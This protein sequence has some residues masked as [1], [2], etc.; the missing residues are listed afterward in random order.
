MTNASWDEEAI[1]KALLRRVEASRL[2]EYLKEPLEEMIHYEGE[3]TFLSASD[4]LLVLLVFTYIDLLGYLY[5]GKNSS[6]NAV[7]FMREYLGRVDKRYEE[8]SGLLYDALR[9]GYIHLATP[10]R[11]ELQD[12]KILDFSFIR[13]GWRE[14]YLKVAKMRETQSTGSTVDIYRLSLDLPLLYKDLL[15]AIDKY[16]EDIRHNEALSDIFRKT[17]E[18]RRKPEKAREE[19]LLGKPY[20]QDSDFAFVRNQIS[21]L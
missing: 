2:E 8:V 6:S 9:H 5:K 12:K 15:S 7:E 4:D 3:R 13:S 17:F 21:N 11:I 10:K 19:V 14:D 20:I 1:G 16:A 18:T